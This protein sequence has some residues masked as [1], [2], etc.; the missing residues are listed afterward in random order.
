[1]KIEV[2]GFPGQVEIDPKEY[3][4]DMDE[5]IKKIILKKIP[6]LTNDAYDK[7]MKGKFRLRTR[8]GVELN[9]GI[10]YRYGLSEEEKMNIMEDNVRFTL[11]YANLPTTAPKDKAAFIAG[12]MEKKSKSKKSKSKKSKSTKSKSKM[13]PFK[14]A[15]E[16]GDDFAPMQSKRTG[17]KKKKKR[18]SKKR[19]KS[20]TRKRR[21]N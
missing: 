11:S 3:T 1:M 19:R 2:V 17:G 7:K 12:R 16:T 6:M 20:K 5:F 21:C 13:I 9:T 8:G 15:W 10:D 18:K 4:G 14:Q